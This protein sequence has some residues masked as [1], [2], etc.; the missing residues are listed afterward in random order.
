MLAELAQRKL[1][2]KIG[3]LRQ[4]VPGRFND[5]HAAMVTEIVAHV[6]YLD[7]A[8]A[9][10]DTRVEEM[11]IPFRA[12]RELLE[13]ITGIAQRNTEIIVAEIGVDMTRFA[14]PGHLA[15]RAGVCP[16]NN[17]SAGRHRST[18]TRSGNAWLQSAL[19]EAAWSA[20]R[21]KDCYLAV[22][23]WRIAKR[24]GQQ[25]AL[26]AIAHTMLVISWHMLN[27]GTV[28]TDLGV[29]YF[30]R[31]DNPDRR[32]RHLINQLEH[33]GYQVKLTPAA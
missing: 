5:H 13:T 25:R 8:I 30:A 33:L 24:R 26:I 32:R 7:A 18:H 22:R 6:D 23:F 27:D 31:N 19:V 4:C 14:T 11:M 28:Y 21:S 20:I 16:G 9:R 2:A 3:D 17:E 29:D 1:R 15:S 10:L 12:A